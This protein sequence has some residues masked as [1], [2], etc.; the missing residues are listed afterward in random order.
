MLAPG[1]YTREDFEKMKNVSELYYIREERS[2]VLAIAG[3]QGF[4]HRYHIQL[5]RK[6]GTPYE[7]LLSL[8]FIMYQ[9]IPC[10]QAMVEDITERKKMEDALLSYKDQLSLL[11]S[12]LSLVE[13][14]EKRKIAVDLHDNIGQILAY[15]NMMLKD[16]KNS[17]PCDFRN[18]L[19]EIHLLIQQS[20]EYT[21]SLTFELGTPLL[22]EIGLES[23]VERLGQEF[24]K[25]HGVTFIFQDDKK[26]KPLQDDVRTVLFQSIRELLTNVVKHAGAHAVTV[27][28]KRKNHSIQATVADDGV[29]FD[30]ASIYDE[31]YLK[32]GFGLFS[33]RERLKNIGGYFDIRSEPGSATRITLTA[34]LEMSS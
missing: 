12:R 6:D 30:V 25:K 27:S 16:L 33:I 28:L 19:E 4:L 21:R 15:A 22:Y 23:T 11:T 3:K 34:P 1:G 31:S 20:I 2:K 8:R 18:S 24:Q 9:R 29:G 17:A 26:A 5:K 7:T 10:V 13:E 32:C 14:R